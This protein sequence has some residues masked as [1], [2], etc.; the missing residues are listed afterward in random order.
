MK[1]RLNPAPLTHEDT[2]IWCRVILSM[3]GAHAGQFYANS[4]FHADRRDADLMLAA[5][6]HPER[7]VYLAIRHGRNVTWSEAID[8]RQG[9]DRL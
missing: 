9:T 5:Q 3:R 6:D 4:G 1:P 2:A 8:L 7:S